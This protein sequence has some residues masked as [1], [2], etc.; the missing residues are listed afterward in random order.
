MHRLLLFLTQELR[1]MSRKSKWYCIVAETL[2]CHSSDISEEPRQSSQPML[3]FQVQPKKDI[4]D[5]N[6]CLARAEFDDW[7]Y[8]YSSQ[9]SFLSNSQQT[10]TLKG[11]IFSKKII[12]RQSKTRR[13]D[14]APFL[15]NIAQ[16]ITIPHN[17]MSL[18]T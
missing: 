5:M 2:A 1:K 13:P 4:L 17:A 10:K 14:S 12:V 6:D 15:Q 3:P 7:L 11:G 18:S 9:C 8:L 16:S